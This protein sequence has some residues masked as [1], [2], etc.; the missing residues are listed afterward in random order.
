MNGKTLK[1]VWEVKSD[2]RLFLYPTDKLV[3]PTSVNNADFATHIAFAIVKKLLIA[4]GLGVAVVD[5]GQIQLQ[6]CTEIVGDELG[7]N[8]RQTDIVCDIGDLGVFPDDGQQA[9]GFRLQLFGGDTSV[10]V[11]TSMQSHNAVG[12]VRFRFQLGLIQ[13]EIPVGVADISL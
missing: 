1:W 4:K 6:F 3:V 13:S 11:Q 10:Q 9:F 5:S 2:N 7:Q 12:E 8:Y